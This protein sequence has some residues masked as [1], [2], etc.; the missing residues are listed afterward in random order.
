MSVV[1]ARPRLVRWLRPFAL[2]ILAVTGVLGLWNGVSDLG[3]VAA[4]WPRAI[5]AGDATYG[6]LGLGALAATL[7]RRALARPL[8]AAWGVMVIAVATAAP[9]VYAEETGWALWLGALVGGAATALIAWG[10]WLGVA[11][12]DREEGRLT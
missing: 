6:A 5:A 7:L 12:R 1:V 4:G 11:A 10:V 8:A 9:V 2:V 3:V